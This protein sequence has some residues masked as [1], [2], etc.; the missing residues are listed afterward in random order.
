LEV[1]IAAGCVNA[2][3]EGAAHHRAMSA[4]CVVVFGSGRSV[5]E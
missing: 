5:T 3:E 4:W 1:P 2:S